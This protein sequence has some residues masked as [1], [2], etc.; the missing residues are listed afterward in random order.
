MSREYPDY[1][2]VGVGVVVWKDNAVLLIQR[3][4]PQGL[5]LEPTGR[6]ART[7][8]DNAR[9]ACAKCVRKPAWK[10]TSKT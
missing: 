10:S 1:P 6:A 7:R 9:R 4:K 3:G 2:M 8:R 5:E